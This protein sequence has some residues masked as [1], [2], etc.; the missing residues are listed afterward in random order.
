M[1]GSTWYLPCMYDV[2]TL[3]T[4]NNTRSMSLLRDKRW[5]LYS[6]VCCCYFCCF[7]VVCLSC[8]EVVSRDKV[9]IPCNI[10][11]WQCILL[12]SLVYF[13]MPRYFRNQTRTL[14]HIITITLADCCIEMIN[15]SNKKSSIEPENIVGSFQYNILYHSPNDAHTY[16]S[17]HMSHFRS[18]PSPLIVV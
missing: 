10:L 2:N 9:I 8:L 18:R 12:F 14:P 1:G 17:V 15:F 5:P 13:S 7:V 4:R 3:H 11:S 16:A 6:G